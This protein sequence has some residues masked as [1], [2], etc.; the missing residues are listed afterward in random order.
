MLSHAPSAAGCRTEY[1]QRI[2][3]HLHAVGVSVA[4]M[5]R[6]LEQLPYTP[7][8]EQLLQELQGGSIA[9]QPCSCIILSD[10]YAVCS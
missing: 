6:V 1:M 2:F 3:D 5:Q 7:G 9:G 4:D 8:M 10:R